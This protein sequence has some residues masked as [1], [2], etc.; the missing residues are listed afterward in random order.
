MLPPQDA[1]VVDEADRAARGVGTAAEAEEEQLVTGFVVL[2]DEAV[3]LA[4]VAGQPQGRDPTRQPLDRRR[5]DAPLVV[6]ALPDAGRVL[7]GDAQRD[8]GDVGRAGPAAVLLVGGVPGAV[9]AQHQPLGHRPPSMG[10][11]S[12]DR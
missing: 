7:V 6:D 4:D 5:A 3:G 9:A 12:A 11:V 2:D 8:L 10:P 1:A